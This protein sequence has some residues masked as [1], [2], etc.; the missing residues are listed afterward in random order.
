[1]WGRAAR[2][3]DGGNGAR[4][5][6][7]WWE[8]SRREGRSAGRSANMSSPL[9]RASSADA[10]GVVIF[11]TSPRE[12]DPRA[13]PTLFHSRQ[14]LHRSPRLSTPPRARYPRYC[15][16]TARC[17]RLVPDFDC[18]TVFHR[19]STAFTGYLRAGRMI[20]P[21]SALLAHARGRRSAGVRN[22]PRPI[23]NRRGSWPATLELLNLQCARAR[24]K[25]ARPKLEC[26][27]LPRALL[28]SHFHPSFPAA[29]RRCGAAR[30]PFDDVMVINRVR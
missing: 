14:G 22:C 27:R 3:G 11:S 4:G 8:E 2:A 26:F 6:R 12:R 9:G 17:D 28:L 24:A 30:L 1:M 19:L 25:K 10:A 16:D 18:R 13:E 15:S 21:R 20:Q 7:V 23:Q 5:A 29:R